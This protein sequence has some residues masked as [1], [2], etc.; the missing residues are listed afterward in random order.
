MA[1]KE[2]Q[3]RDALKGRSTLNLGGLN[4][5]K[6]DLGIKGGVIPIADSM[7]IKVS[8]GAKTGGNPSPVGVPGFGSF[9][10]EGFLNPEVYEGI[11]SQNIATLAA[12]SNV[13]VAKEYA[14]SQKEVARINKSASLG[15]SRLNLKGTQ[16]ASDKELEGVLGAENIRAKGAIDLQGI[17][18]AGAANVENI[19]GEYGIKG[20]KV[21]QNTAI[22]GSLVSA[23]NF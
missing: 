17:I 13:D 22:L 18:N 15:V 9:S 1:S 4:K 16:Y 14:K 6:K 10:S 11:L 7:G 3:I 19:R 23:F 12:Q 5:I 20:K 8:Y 2:Q 21:D